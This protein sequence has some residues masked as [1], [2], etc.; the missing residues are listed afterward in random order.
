MAIVN[1]CTGCNSPINDM[2]HLIVGNHQSYWHMGCLKCTVCQCMLQMEHKCYTNNGKFYCCE[3]Y[4][5]LIKQQSTQIDT[6]TD[7]MANEPISQCRKCVKQIRPN[8]YVINISE[9]TNT[10]KNPNNHN[11]DSSSSLYHLNCFSCTDCQIL[12]SPGHPYGIY[13]QEV[14]CTQHYSNQL[15]FPQQQN[16]QTEYTVLQS[17]SSSVHPNNSSKL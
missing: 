12:I 9:R 15:N 11:S 2:Y 17:S 8:D 1:M 4:T 13:N 6:K 14:Y 10:K 16:H 5:N 3:D 7:V